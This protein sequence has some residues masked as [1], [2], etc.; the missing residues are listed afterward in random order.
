MSHPSTPSSSL[1]V[2]G[3]LW[4]S[5]V[6]LLA[7]RVPSL[8][9]PAGG[10]QG[11]YAYTATRVLAGEVPYRD[12]WDQKPPA[13]AFVYALLLKL[14]PHES[15][16][17][18]GD[19][20][21]AALTAGLLIL[22]FR[23]RG[24][25]IAGGAAAFVF[26]LFG[27]P[28]LQRLSGVYVRG[29]CEPF[30][31]L[32]ITAALALTATPGR[33]RWH[34]VSAG[35]C[36]AL[37]C[38]LKYNAIAYALPV[39]IAGWVWA[40]GGSSTAARIKDLAAIAV[41]VAVPSVAILGYFGAHGALHDLWLATID[42]NLRYSNE[43]YDGASSV[44]V[45]LITLPFDRARTDMLWFLGGLGSVALVWRVKSS[46]LNVV[47][48]G[49]LA[50][51]LLSIVINGQRNLPNYFVQA[52][53]ALAAA[54]A[55]GGQLALS[56]RGWLTYGLACAVVL[57]LWRVGDEGAR[58]TFRWGG[59]PGLLANVRFD[60][61]Y[62]RGSISRHEYLSR[63]RGLQKFDALEI[64][65]L[66]Q[67]LRETT[68]PDDAVLVFGFL[69][70][71]VC[72]QSERVS[73]SRFFWS[74]P[75]IIEFAADVPGYGSAGLLRD[76]LR[77]PPAVVALQKEQ[78]QSEAFFMGSPP[79]RAWLESGYVRD[80]ETPM[81]TVWRRARRPDLL[82]APPVP[83]PVVTPAVAGSPAA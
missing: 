62:A 73:S 45:Y 47:L 32:C 13:I 64:E 20:L 82:A 28:S 40:P 37:A 1:R 48:L 35:A 68:K 83:G 16:V 76:L 74:R 8:V 49:W 44:P 60:L 34:L 66:A 63:F 12:A 19:L 67:Y 61:A 55:A 38:W 46:A 31:A 18:L 65:E 52:A 7:L 51:A 41:G 26:L 33:R 75:V 25:H 29:Q 4:L 10:D 58:G 69:G 30:I 3:V 56:R 17:A 42:Y 23:R 9:Q 24:A 57:G 14:W 81:F 54:A 6:V 43:T 78:W 21:A 79:L 15:A 71:S 39:A 80:H 59:I 2:T 50:A 11:L 22:L 70:G 72:W 36:L 53:P 27:H 77:R 5:L